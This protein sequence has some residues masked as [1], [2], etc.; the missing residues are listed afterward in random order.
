MKPD[1]LGAERDTRNRESDKHEHEKQRRDE[2]GQPRM[3][4][5]EYDQPWYKEQFQELHRKNDEQTGAK[6]ANAPWHDARRNANKIRTVHDVLQ[7]P[8]EN[9]ASWEA[10]TW[11]GKPEGRMSWEDHE[12]KR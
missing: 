8:N 6:I 3:R 10:G 9:G 7:G 11:T 2:G 12:S 1:P 5:E 4:E